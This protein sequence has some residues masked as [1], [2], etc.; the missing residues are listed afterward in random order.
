MFNQELV[1]VSQPKYMPLD[2]HTTN[3][4]VKLVISDKN[5]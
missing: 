1:L 3:D 2:I 5:I 4:D